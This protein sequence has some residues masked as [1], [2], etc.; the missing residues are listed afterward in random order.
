MRLASV[1]ESFL[2]NLTV[3][4]SDSMPLVVT[5]GIILLTA[6]LVFIVGF[7]AGAGRPATADR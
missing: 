1:I 2:T 7:L 3:T 5:G 6:L 4:P